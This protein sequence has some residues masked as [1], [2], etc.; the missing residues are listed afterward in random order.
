MSH[1]ELN[2]AQAVLMVFPK[3]FGYDDQTATSNTFQHHPDK[4]IEVTRA[5][6]QREFVGLVEKLRSNSIEVLVAGMSS[7]AAS[8]M[9]NALFPNNW[10][11]TWPNGD[12]YLYPM[13]TE[14]RRIERSA[15]VLEMIGEQF[16]INN[17]IDISAP[18]LQGQF[19]ES[20]GVMLF[21]HVNRLA[22]ATPSI[23]CDQ[24]L[25]ERHVRELGYEPVTFASM[26]HRGGAIYHT[27]IMLAI[28]THTAIVCDAAIHPDDRDRVMSQLRATNRDVVNISYPQLVAFAA[29]ALEIQNAEGN[30]F[31]VMSQGA[32]ESLDESQRERLLAHNEIISSPLT[33]IE[34]VGGG[35]ARC[36]LGE[37]FLARR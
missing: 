21:D 13:A 32:H 8:S 15:A 23:R 25:F 2:S 18:E 29:N 12:V 1:R 10:F 26:D 4:N 36:M 37:I 6:A 35:S 5:E 7:D 22:F 16:V 17:V 28:Q 33:T 11:S 34:T 24:V 27:N 20:T 14:T 30:T 9:P 31:L 19:L 3:T